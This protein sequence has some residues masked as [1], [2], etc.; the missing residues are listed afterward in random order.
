VGGTFASESVYH[1][2]AY[3]G[4][5]LWLSRSLAPTDYPSPSFVSTIITAS[6]PIVDPLSVGRIIL[7]AKMLHRISAFD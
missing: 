4:V 1:I 6:A 3:A 5:A 2:G 7:K